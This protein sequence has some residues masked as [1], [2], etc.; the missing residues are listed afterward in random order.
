MPYIASF[1]GVIII[2][3]IIAV[4][5]SCIM[6]GRTDDLYDK[7]ISICP[8]CGK[9]QMV[10][11]DHKEYFCSKCGYFGRPNWKTLLPGGDE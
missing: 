8:Q 3:I 9:Y 5:C 10:K 1:I 4:Y 7:K 6:A 2:L 11:T